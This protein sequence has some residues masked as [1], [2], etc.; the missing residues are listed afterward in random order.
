MKRKQAETTTQEEN[1]STL[2]GEAA[3]STANAEEASALKR[4]R[5]ATNPPQQEEKNKTDDGAAAVALTEE[6]KNKWRVPKRKVAL[7]IGYNGAEF[8]G[9]QRNP[10]VRTV[11]EELEKAI[12]EAGGIAPFNAGSFLKV[13]WSRCARTDK[14]V[15]AVGN[16]ISLK[17][18]L[19]PEGMLDRINAALPPD[20]RLFEIYRVTGT[21]GAKHSVDSRT[22]E[23]LLPFSCLLPENAAEE[24]D[25]ERRQ[26]KRDEAIRRT[27]ELL[28]KYVG[29]HNFFN[30]TSKKEKSDPSAL[31][32]IISFT[33]SEPFMLDG[34]EFVRLVINGQSFLLNQIRKMI[35]LVVLLVRKNLSEE[36]I[37]MAYELRYSIPMAPGEGL[38]LLHCLFDTYSNGRGSSLPP[39]DWRNA[40]EQM[41][42]FKQRVIYPCIVK[43][44]REAGVFKQWE[45][46]LDGQEVDLEALRPQ[47]E[48][49]RQEEAKRKEERERKKQERAARRKLYEE[50]QRKEK[51]QQQQQKNEEEKKKEKEQD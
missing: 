46:V 6:D 45:S 49:E 51:E 34:M 16:I 20:I 35:G 36:L 40:A 10:G 33:C 38:M 3:T 17:M 48:A 50:A 4:P 26:R 44:E 30:F 25:E 47:W 24:K 13:N 32:Y 21:F 31:R 5:E 2:A 28:Q 23:Y 14:G 22:Y 19:E 37:E 12:V 9:M 11:E 18:L 8:A 7:L 1:A 42:E 41:D 29:H 15:H 43:C 27:N 39:L